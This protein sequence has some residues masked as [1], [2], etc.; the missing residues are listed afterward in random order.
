MRTLSMS[1]IRTH[2]CKARLNDVAI[3]ISTWMEE[4][5]SRDVSNQTRVRRYSLRSSINFWTSS[6]WFSRADPISCSH[7]RAPDYFTE[8]INSDRGFW[9]WQ[10]ASYIN[11][12]LGF[13][14]RSDALHQAGEDCRPNT[15]GMYMITTNS[16][17]PFA[18]GQWSMAS[19]ESSKSGAFYRRDPLQEQIDEW[20]KLDGEFNND[21]RG[22]HFKATAMGNAYDWSRLNQIESEFSEPD[23]LNVNF[24]EHKHTTASSNERWRQ[25]DK[26]KLK[27]NPLFTFVNDST[28]TW[29]RHHP[30]SHL[31]NDDFQFPKVTY[32]RT[33]LFL[34]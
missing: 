21:N 26:F 30:H 19:T 17:A 2:W 12:L 7:H 10:C 29:Q 34:Q 3:P 32:W 11:Y 22:G 25:N 33:T 15:K 6:F 9:G 23:K 13:C 1:F 28:N 18:S 5:F 24:N 20:G 8:S 27:E 14:P 4:S 31:S 16:A